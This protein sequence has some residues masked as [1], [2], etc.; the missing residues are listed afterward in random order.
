M[1]VVEG[2]HDTEQD[3]RRIRV[4]GAAIEHDGK[5][6]CACRGAGKQ[7]AGKWEFPG[8]KIEAGETPEQALHREIHEELRCDIVVAQALCTTTQ[9]YDF[10]TVVLT[11]FLCRL[12]GENPHISEHQQLLWLA[13]DVLPTLD[14][15]AA[16]RHTADM[17]STMDVKEPAGE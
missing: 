2:S 13:P 3:G 5:I 4:V 10:G 8:G 14:W 9:Q 1:S 7:L 12:R 6:L 11:V 16:D 15:A 17:I